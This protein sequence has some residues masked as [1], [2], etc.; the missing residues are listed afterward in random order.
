MKKEINLSVVIPC[1]NE[2][3]NISNT[4]LKVIRILRDYQKFEILVV[5]YGSKDKT[6]SI[7]N[8]LIKSNKKLKLISL[9]KNQGVQN[10]IY[11]GAKNSK[12]KY[13]THFPGDDS[14]E[15]K[16][17]KNLIRKVG[18]KDLV[19][20]YRK[21][22]HQKINFSRFFLSKTLIIIMNF[23]TK[24]KL[25]DFHGPY[26]CETR[27][28]KKKFRSKR[29]DG[30]IEILNYI[31]SKNVSCIEVPVYVRVKTIQNTN[32][33]KIKVCLDFILTLLRLFFLNFF[34]SK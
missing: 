24:K 21:D 6:K 30:Q 7:V 17:I 8:R 27:F 3:K 31:L 10:A 28:L 2:Q 13:I 19:M 33:V 25:K 5:D 11:I 14:F 29:Y 23:L 32:V 34:K 4:V 1:F 9:K 16:G 26:V 12:Y 20:G 18:E 15:S 22:Y